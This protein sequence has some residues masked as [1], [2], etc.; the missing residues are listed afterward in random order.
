MFFVFVR[1]ALPVFQRRASLASSKAIP[2]PYITVQ[3]ES[4]IG[5]SW[6]SYH[7]FPHKAAT[8]QQ[9][10]ID[11]IKRN[12][13]PSWPIITALLRLPRPLPPRRRVAIHNIPRIRAKVVVVA[14]RDE[15]AEATITLRPGA[16][17][18][19]RLLV[20]TDTTRNSLLSISHSRT[21]PN[22]R[23]NTQD[24][25]LR[26]TS[27]RVLADI[28]KLRSSHHSSGPIRDTSIMPQAPMPYRLRITTP[29]TLSTSI[30]ST[31][32]STSSSSRP[33][34]TSSRHRSSSNNS[35]HTEPLPRNPMASRMLPRNRQVVLSSGWL[36]P[37]LPPR[38]PRRPRTLLLT[39]PI[40]SST[41]VAVAVEGTTARPKRN[42]WDHRSGWALTTLLLGTPM[43]Q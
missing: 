23:L 43:L 36:P 27:T 1:Q 19:T 42:R 25:T 18:I 6:I 8:V 11:E 14:I 40:S 35:R 41:E 30:I 5:R 33:T 31:S 4:L 13:E 22:T 20:R 9:A 26:S 16:G 2:I 24:S 3:S 32:S 39:S 21:V 15:G 10:N 37:R 28:P 17:L 7:S 29:T 34:G 12:D 38:L